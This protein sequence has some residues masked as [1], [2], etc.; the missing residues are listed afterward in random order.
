MIYRELKKYKPKDVKTIEMLQGQKQTR[1]VAWSFYTKEAQ[2]S[3]FN[4]S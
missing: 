1:F 2:K 4:K 3:W